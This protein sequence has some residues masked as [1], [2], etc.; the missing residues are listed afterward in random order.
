LAFQMGVQF[1]RILDGFDG[2][3]EKAEGLLNPPRG[4]VTGPPGPAGYLI[5]HRVNDSFIVVNRLLKAGCD[6]YWLNK[7]E[8]VDGESLGP[9]AIWIPASPNALPILQRATRE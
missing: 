9:G 4:S 3:F 1:D 6:V 5:S 7:A 8:T 2:P